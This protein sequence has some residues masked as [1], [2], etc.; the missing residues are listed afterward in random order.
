MNDSSKTNSPYG[1]NSGFGQF[2]DL[3][4]HQTE[5][6]DWLRERGLAEVL[7]QTEITDGSD[8]PKIRI[9]LSNPKLSDP[10][11]DPERALR[12]KSTYDALLTCDLTLKR[13]FSGETLIS[14]NATLARLPLMTEEGVFALSG[15]KRTIVSQIVRAP[16]VFFAREPAGQAGLPSGSATFVSPRGARLELSVNQDSVMTARLGKARDINAIT[17]ARCLD[18][19]LAEILDQLDRADPSGQIGVATLERAG[20]AAEEKRACLEKAF[21]A[22]NP[23]APFDEKRARQH[24]SDRLTNPKY[25]SLSDLGRRR[26]NAAVHQDCPSPPTSRALAP[27][28][29]LAAMRETARTHLGQREPDDPDHL[30]NK[31]VRR[32][33]E[34][35]AE[36]ISRGL[37]E[38]AKKAEAKLYSADIETLSAASP[39]KLVS[40][41]ALRKEI[42]N[43]FGTS[44]LCQFTDD[45]NPLSQI[46]HLRRI[47]A[48]G[49]GGIDRRRAGVDVRDVHHSY[50]GRICPIESPEGQN[51]GLVSALAFG[52]RI[53]WDGF[54][55]APYRKVKKS[56]PAD[57]RHEA[58]G[59]TAAA[60]LIRPDESPI[61]SQ[62]DRISQSHL[63]QIERFCPESEV[64][65]RPYLSGRTDWLRPFE[66]ERFL[67]GQA[68]PE[69]NLL[70]EILTES[71]EA[72][73]PEGAALVAPESLDYC[74]LS[75][76]QMFSV[77]ALMIPFLAHNDANRAL[78]GANMQ[79]QA[80]PLVSPDP[81]AVSTGM[82]KL[83]TKNPGHSVVARQDG[84]VLSA[85]AEVIT[86]WPK[87]GN[88]ERKKPQTYRVWPVR[89][90]NSNTLIAQKTTVR[91]GQIV[92][93]G[94]TLADGYAASHG[95]AALGQN[96]L[97]G[98]LSWD[99]YNYEDSI[100]LS[101]TLIAEGKF[102]SAHIKTLSLEIP[103]GAEEEITPETP[104]LPRR[105]KARLDSSG[106]ILEGSRIK[107]GDTLVAARA[108]R[109]QP[110]PIERI[111]ALDSDSEKLAARY[112]NV[113]LLA[114]PSDYGVVI[115]ARLVSG[116]PDDPLPVGTKSAA[117]ISVAS[118]KKL[119]VGDKMSGRHGN[120][121]IVSATMP[122][123][124][125]PMLP[126]GEPIEIA[127]NPLGLPSR[128]NLGQLLET[129]LGM[130]T[131]ETGGR[132]TAQAFG[133][134]DKQAVEDALATEW[135]RQ[136]RIELPQDERPA[137]AATKIWLDLAEPND[138]PDQIA[139]IA[140]M[141]ELAGE[142]PPASGKHNLRDGRT[143]E[144][145]PGT[146][147]VGIK[148]LLKLSHLASDKM[149]ARSTGPYQAITQQPLGGK[150]MRG[151]QR[152]GEMEIWALAS[153]GASETLAESL[154]IRSDDLA[155]RELA[156]RN[157]ALG[158][159]T[160]MEN[161]PASFQ[162]LA[163]ELAALRIKL[164]AESEDGEWSEPASSAE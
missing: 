84:T 127:L 33:G 47:S 118:V 21:A 50:Y 160:P 87:A 70:G 26:L 128:M 139:A 15:S 146:Q 24:I 89:K 31:R 59:R 10:P 37:D 152:L 151:G 137:L 143:G 82:E 25:Y 162:T 93:E 61:V 17:L 121:G 55:L 164:L 105:A 65:V 3:I 147:T 23:R 42:R 92:R 134:D 138:D 120:K 149:H 48:L 63:E 5:S 140:R 51:I 94:D 104:N 129:H 163:L 103:T 108:P 57:R 44:P 11:I 2:S 6:F 123:E 36:A 144:R 90:S 8:D 71:V 75:T 148:H 46:T 45:T 9:T 18:L 155:G 157:M 77:S 116:D 126:N 69:A 22:I 53:D 20:E 131:R 130:A 124:D 58:L 115:E 98:Y 141:R 30:G 49:P 79:R 34:L 73:G 72:R 7:S 40:F 102:A 14:R 19:E 88:P 97:V 119:S 91:T 38:S 74:D 111:L 96:C 150:S 41:G 32:S 135:A 60:E 153:Y 117:R 39:L 80:L 95:E 114:G 101:E 100:V 136:N 29:L 106:L 83:L 66:E 159:P 154:T 81:P 64:P 85:T 76:W 54:I 122:P 78:M 27:D 112:R 86:V 4:R 132:A 62:G 68:D 110:E 156:F 16:G 161:R 113:S 12:T 158:R 1:A 52:A 13:L 125:M 28:D 99:G 67:I 43:F 145:I 35:I 56:V 109:E 142:P 133:T 107:P